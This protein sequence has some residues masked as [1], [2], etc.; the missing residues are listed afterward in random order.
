MKVKMRAAKMKKGEKRRRSPARKRKENHVI[1]RKAKSIAKGRRGISQARK[2]KMNL[3]KEMLMSSGKRPG[4][5]RRK[6]N[7]KKLIMAL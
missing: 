2:V 1:R 6:T 7:S 5:K 3:K 4:L